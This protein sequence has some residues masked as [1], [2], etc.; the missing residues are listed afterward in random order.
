MSTVVE[1]MRQ[2]EPCTTWARRKRHYS[3][4]LRPSLAGRGRSGWALC[5]AAVMDQLRVQYWEI[6]SRRRTRIST[7]PECKK[8]ARRRGGDSHRS[9]ITAYATAL[10]AALLLKADAQRSKP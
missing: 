9:E 2:P 8:C 5:G 10:W 4:N 6:G 3:T 7:L 1:E